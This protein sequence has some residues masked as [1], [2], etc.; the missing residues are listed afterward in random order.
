[1]DRI[2]KNIDELWSELTVKKEGSK[3]QKALDRIIK[4]LSKYASTFSYLPNCVLLTQH[5]RSLEEQDEK[6]K[7]MLE[8]GRLDRWARNSVDAEELVS[9]CDAIKDALR[10]FLVS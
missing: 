1:M 4:K 2:L 9:S 7:A 5:P 8:R 6:I 3:D 10:S